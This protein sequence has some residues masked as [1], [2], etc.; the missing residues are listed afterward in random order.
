MTAKKMIARNKTLVLQDIVDSCQD[1]ANIPLIAAVYHDCEVFVSTSR[2]YPMQCF[3]SADSVCFHPAIS[4]LKQ[5][6]S[7]G[8]RL[9]LQKYPRG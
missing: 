2:K 6:F 4:R 1:A 5:Q 9:F 7:A 8:Y 3:S